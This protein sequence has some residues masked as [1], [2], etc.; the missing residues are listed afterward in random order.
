MAVSNPCL[1]DQ[2]TGN[3]IGFVAV[4]F[5]PFIG[6]PRAPLKVIASSAILDSRVLVPPPHKG[7]GFSHLLTRHQAEIVS[8][9]Y[10]DSCPCWRDADAGN[11]NTVAVWPST[12]R[13]T[14]TTSPLG[15]SSASWCM[16]GRSGLT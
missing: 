7:G 1:T 5:H 15:N 11:C 16:F 2:L 4:D 3:R 14:R 6:L 8:G 13:V 12:S 10:R 9:A